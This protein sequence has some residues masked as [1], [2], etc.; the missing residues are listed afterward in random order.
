VCVCVCVLTVPL[1]PTEPCTKWLMNL[2]VYKS[3]DSGP[4][5]DRSATKSS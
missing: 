2:L 1:V 5:G 4:I 3:H